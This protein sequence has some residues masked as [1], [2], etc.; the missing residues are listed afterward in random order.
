MLAPNQIAPLTG[1]HLLRV[2]S[3]ADRETLLAV[4]AD[5]DRE[6]AIVA[7][8]GAQGVSTHHLRSALMAEMRDSGAADEEACESCRRRPAAFFLTC[9]PCTSTARAW[10]PAVR[11]GTPG[12]AH[13][14]DGW[15]VP[16]P[17]TPAPTG[18][19]SLF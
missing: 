16:T 17:P 1:P 4:W 2:L 15:T 5:W 10:L 12:A 11:T 13:V 9:A 14:L 6:A 3:R 8:D 19:G 7:R 18:Q